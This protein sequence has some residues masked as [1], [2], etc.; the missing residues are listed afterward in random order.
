M[1]PLYDPDTRWD[2]LLGPLR[3]V[4]GMLLHQGAGDDEERTRGAAFIH[5]VRRLGYQ[6][7]REVEQALDSQEPPAVPLLPPDPFLDPA[8]EEATCHYLERVNQAIAA[9]EAWPEDV[10]DPVTFRQA[11]AYYRV[12]AHVPP[13]PP[14]EVHPEMDT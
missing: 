5:E 14:R 7:A 4:E 9:G 11:S 2:R 13:A 8:E 6:T 10:P 1:V 3:A 12:T